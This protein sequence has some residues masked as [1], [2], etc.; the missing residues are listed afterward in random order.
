MRM[1]G[2]SSCEETRASCFS[3]LVGEYLHSC[4]F[5]AM[6]FCKYNVSQS[7]CY[8]LRKQG[9]FAIALLALPSNS[10]ISSEYLKR[11]F[12]ALSIPDLGGFIQFSLSGAWLSRTVRMT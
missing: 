1:W 5:A 10:D 4:R 6:I 11:L 7:C 3:A 12:R 9:T 2:V 8:T